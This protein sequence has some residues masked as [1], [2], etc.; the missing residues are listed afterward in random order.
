MCVCV[1]VCV[2]GGGEETSTVCYI[3]CLSGQ[4]KVWEFCALMSV[5]TMSWFQEGG[6]W[7]A[8]LILNFL[9][10]FS[11]ETAFNVIQI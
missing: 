5:A 8:Y 10:H 7:G 9:Q 11:M 3:L 4:G 6:E 1:C 2:G